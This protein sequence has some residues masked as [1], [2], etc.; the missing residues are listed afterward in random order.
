MNLI[1]ADEKYKVK[2]G[3]EVYEIEYPSFDQ[4]LKIS[5]AFGAIDGDGEKSIKL[6]KKW[7]TDLGLN[8]KFF[9]LNQ[10]KSKH[11]MQVW[12]ELNTVKK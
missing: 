10:V 1:I 9:E 12:S 4:A 6:M 7:L 11:I 5:K 8:P 3:A 2:V